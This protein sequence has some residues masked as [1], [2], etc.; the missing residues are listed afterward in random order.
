MRAEVNIRGDGILSSLLCA[1]VDS[2]NPVRG[3]S[4]AP[5]APF[6]KF[7]E[8]RLD[9]RNLGKVARGTRNRFLLASPTAII[10][11]LFLKGEHSYGE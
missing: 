11:R 7:R 1:G 10:L 5:Y 4:V 3:E 9:W 6:E 2:R 8:E